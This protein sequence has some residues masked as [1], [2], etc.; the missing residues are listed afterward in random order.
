MLF[1][2]NGAHILTATICNKTAW[3]DVHTPSAPES[4]LRSKD[5]WDCSL[6][7]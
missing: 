2:R 5:I 4:A 6:W 7:H 3:L 1:L